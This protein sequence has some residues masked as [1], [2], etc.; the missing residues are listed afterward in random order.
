[1]IRD[2]KMSSPVDAIPSNSALETGFLTRKNI[3]CYRSFWDYRLSEVYEVLVALL[4]PR[5]AM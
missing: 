3:P 2:G 5:R 1:M 4:L